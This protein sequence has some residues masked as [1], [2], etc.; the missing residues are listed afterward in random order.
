MKKTR[1]SKKMGGGETTTGTG[2][3]LLAEP[4][5][6]C[7]PVHVQQPTDSTNKTEEVPEST[8]LFFRFLFLFL[9]IALGT[10]KHYQ[11][12]SMQLHF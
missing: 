4:F 9:K 12:W 11:L 10:C 6:M 1:Q 2:T 3:I 5:H 7:I 8:L